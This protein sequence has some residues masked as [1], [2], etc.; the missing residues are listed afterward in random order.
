MKRYY[1]LVVVLTFMCSALAQAQSR[2]GTGRQGMAGQRPLGG[3]MGFGMGMCAAMAIAPPSAAMMDRFAGL[4][5]DDQPARLKAVL[6]DSDKKLATLREKAA[7]ASR[8]LRQAVFAEGFNLAEVQSL[9]AEAQKAEAAILNAEIQ[10]WA[11][12]RGILNSKQVGML[13]DLLARP[14]GRPMPGGPPVSPQV[15]FPSPSP[16]RAQ[17]L[18]Q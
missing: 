11:Q 9:A 12:I 1:V 6:E 16:P 18:E 2:T 10:T 14:S 7:D 15:P 4:L 17:Y 8:A 5:E 3:M 13:Q